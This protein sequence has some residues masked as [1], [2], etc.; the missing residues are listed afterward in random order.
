MPWKN[1]EMAGGRR[2]TPPALFLWHRFV[3]LYGPGTAPRPPPSL[4]RDSRS[5]TPSGFSEVMLQQDA[6][7]DGPFPT[8]APLSRRPFRRSPTSRALPGSA[9]WNC[10]QALGLLPACP[11]LAPGGNSTSGRNSRPAIPMDYARPAPLFPALVITRPRRCSGI[12]FHQPYAVS[13]RECG[14]RGW[15]ACSRCAGI[16]TSPSSGV[17]FERELAQLL[18]PP[19]ARRFQTRP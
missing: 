9:C 5:L 16:S 1:P 19:P 12:A 2:E 13:G 17:P 4:A 10:G 7:R 11:L 15:R 14:A 3:A 18:S 6:D 8:N